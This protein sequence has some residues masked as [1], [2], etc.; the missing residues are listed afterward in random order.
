M[1]H[2]NALLFSEIKSETETF[3]FFFFFPSLF[4]LKYTEV[5]L[6]FRSTPAKAMVPAKV[7]ITTQMWLL[8]SN[9]LSPTWHRHYKRYRTC[10]KGEA[11]FTKNQIWKW[12][13]DAAVGTV[14]EHNSTLTQVSM[15]PLWTRQYF[16][17]ISSKKSYPTTSCF[18]FPAP[19]IVFFQKVHWPQSNFPGDI[20]C[21]Y[22]KINSISSKWLL[23]KVHNPACPP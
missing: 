11:S 21:A 23:M 14:M 15:K 9:S 16:C 12:L 19:D 17:C 22:L 7:I 5:K 20:K 2:Y 6:R 18:N 10:W 13:Y 4:L 1:I 3:C 8:F